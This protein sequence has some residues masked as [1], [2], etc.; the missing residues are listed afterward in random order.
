MNEDRLLGRR[1]SE[2]AA[3]PPTRRKQRFF[4]D[5]R[6]PARR[7]IAVPAL[8]W[9]PVSALA[10][11]HALPREKAAPPPRGGRTAARGPRGPHRERATSCSPSVPWAAKARCPIAARTAR[12]AAPRSLSRNAFPPA[13]CARAASVCIAAGPGGSRSRA[14]RP[15]RRRSRPGSPVW[16][17]IGMTPGA[18]ASARAVCRTSNGRD[19]PSVSTIATRCFAAGEKKLCVP[20]APSA[21]RFVAVTAS[22]VA[23]GGL[24][25]A[26]PAGPSARTR[27][28]R[29]RA[30]DREGRGRSGRPRRTGRRSACSRSRIAA[31]TGA[32]DPRRRVRRTRREHRARDVDD[33]EAPR[34]PCAR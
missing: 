16:M 14:A 12:A 2:F 9:T 30:S 4:T 19:S 22:V 32:G 20:S 28:R 24:P 13:A 17:K 21:P 33:E 29:E 34:R 5:V 8:P 6:R 7:P 3:L 27:L 10:G 1:P 26:Q 25:T 11:A 23:G 18:W 31:C 15:D